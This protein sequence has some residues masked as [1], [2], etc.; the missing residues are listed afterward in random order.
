MATEAAYWKG[1]GKGKGSHS[2]VSDSSWPH[3]LQPTRLLRPWDPPGKSIGVG[4]HHLLRWMSLPI[5]KN[6][7]D[8][9]SAITRLSHCASSVVK[10]GQLK[11]HHTLYKP[12]GRS[13]ADLALP[14]PF[15]AMIRQVLIDD[16]LCAEVLIRGL[17]WYATVL[18]VCV[19]SLS[20]LGF[21]MRIWPPPAA[22]WLKGERKKILGESTGRRLKKFFFQELI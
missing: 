2:V 16:I 6:V 10:R 17:A 7:T 1:K 11:G 5:C 3:G 12:A 14:N 18:M 22:Y 9:N 20:G 4:C 13:R 15:W 21:L 19:T 8:E